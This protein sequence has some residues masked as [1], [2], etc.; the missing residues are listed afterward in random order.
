MKNYEELAKKILQLVGGK[1][2][3]SDI[4]HCMT[5]LRF[6]LK[7]NGLA[8]VEELKKLEGVMGTQ[9][10]QN[11]LQVILG[12]AVENVYNSI[13][14]LS[15]LTRQSAIDENLDLDLIKKE[16]LTVKSAINNVFNVFSAA[17]NPLVPLFVTI[18]VVNLV[19]VLI[20]PVFLGLV[21]E[22]S[23]IYK[24]FYNIG[25]AIIY[26]LPILVAYT[27]ARKFN[28]SVH[29]SLALAGLLLYP[30]Y[31]AMVTEGVSYTVFGLPVYMASYGGSIIPILLIVW[32]QSYIE[33]L[34]N[35]YMPDAVKIILV[36]SLTVIVMLP[37]AFV[38]LGPLGAYIGTALSQ[39][40]MAL[41]NTAGPVETTLYGGLAIIG[42]ATGIS[43]PIFF[44]AMA[45]FFATGSEFAVMPISLVTSNWAV[46]GAVVG[47]I[48]KSKNA[49]D[50]Q[51]GITC[52]TSHILSGVSEPSI[53]GIL[54]NHRKTLIAGSLGGALAGLY[55]GIFKVGIYSWG[56]TNFMN[57]VAFAGGPNNMNF[58][59][60]CIAAGVAFFGA[61]ALTLVMYK[62][63]EAH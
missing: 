1:E 55:L 25:Q 2:N 57:V 51:L 16:K 61:M 39:G 30:A 13:I 23:D 11:E 59:N 50:R 53:F 17:M 27:A 58:I 29:I 7:D 32:V 41:Y 63:E 44:V 9:I 5:R 19:A 28:A 21:T 26:F 4:F 36:P 18:G 60:G 34:L 42:L 54:F 46:M 62:A 45:S 38:V 56:P 48:I 3:V 22:D 47:F 20:G 8:K 14:K 49:R 37:L 12:P 24:N 31:T 43:R 6:N 15:G 35:R 33:R 52:F 10:A 40:V